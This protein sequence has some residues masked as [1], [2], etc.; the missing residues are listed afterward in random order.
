MDNV[1][2][3]IIVAVITGGF[4][5]FAGR[6]TNRANANA[7]D[8]GTFNGLVD[9]VQKLSD[10]LIL[11]KSS[12]TALWSYVYDLIE[13]IISKGHTPPQPPSEL[14]TNPKLIKLLNKVAKTK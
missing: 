12:N 3:A 5:F 6:M 14:D 10:D 13:F 8:V 9:R 4:T 1:T 7:V 11:I 2:G